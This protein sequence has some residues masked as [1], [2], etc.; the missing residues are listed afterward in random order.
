MCRRWRWPGLVQPTRTSARW[1]ERIAAIEGVTHSHV[2]P[3]MSRAQYGL[4]LYLVT[5]SSYEGTGSYPSAVQAVPSHETYPCWLAHQ[6]PAIGAAMIV[7]TSA[8]GQA[9]SR[10]PRGDFVLTSSTTHMVPAA[11]SSNF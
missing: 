7:M 5:S 1:C 4:F 6:P 2:S 8:A 3:R 10:E 9:A 11:V